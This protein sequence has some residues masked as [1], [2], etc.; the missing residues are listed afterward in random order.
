MFIG[1]S[2]FACNIGSEH[3]IGLAGSGAASGIGVGAFEINALII[4]QLLGWVFLPVYIASGVATLPEYMNKRFG[5]NRIRV[6]LSFL[7]LILYIFT[8]ISV[9]LY[10]GGLFIKI[11]LGWN[12][13]YSIFLVLSL[14]AICTMTGVLKA[15]IYID[16]LQTF[17]MV[18]GGLTLMAFSFREIGGVQNL[19]PMYMNSSFEYLSSLEVNSSKV[20]CSM[21]KKNAF[22][23]L[24]D[25]GDSE[26]PWLGFLLGQTPGSIW[27]WCSDQVILL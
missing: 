26:L 21:P 5:G 18:A 16:F 13:Y 8:K 17:I 9:N 6:Y 3:F 19:Y 22:Q 25:I 20:E 4:I 23:M 24:R 14:T 2:L 1:A 27:Y 11:A 15:V 10:S 7:S 12:L